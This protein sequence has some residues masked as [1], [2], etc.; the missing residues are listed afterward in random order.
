M[1]VYVYNTTNNIA[2]HG[3]Y[4]KCHVDFPAGSVGKESVCQHRRHGFDP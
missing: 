1:C 2:K 3:S 4:E